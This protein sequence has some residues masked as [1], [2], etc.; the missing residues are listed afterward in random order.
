MLE[1]V[2]R[3]IGPLNTFVQQLAVIGVEPAVKFRAEKRN[4]HARF[5]TV[6]QAP[7]LK[8]WQDFRRSSKQKGYVLCML[9]KYSR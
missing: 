3:T 7:S 9:P 1:K 2:L 6:R 4:D 5:L 8:K